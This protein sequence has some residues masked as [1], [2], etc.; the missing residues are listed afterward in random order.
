MI[1][2]HLKS[3]IKT[4]TN[5]VNMRLD[6]TIFSKVQY[7]YKTKL[8]CSWWKCYVTDPLQNACILWIPMQSFCL[9]VT[10]DGLHKM[11][12]FLS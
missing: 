11:L 4:Y 12:L 8:W 1:P 6:D 5:T 7:M 9:S 10:M 3:Q 2:T